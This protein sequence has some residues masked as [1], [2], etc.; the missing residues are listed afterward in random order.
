MR[1]GGWVGGEMKL[2]INKNA[3]GIKYGDMGTVYIVSDEL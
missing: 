2:I 1:R 3:F